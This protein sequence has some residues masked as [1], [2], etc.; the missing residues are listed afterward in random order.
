[1][2]LARENQHFHLLHWTVGGK[3]RGLCRLGLNRP[4]LDEFHADR[5]HI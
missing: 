4:A 1:V 2:L 5:T 3:Y